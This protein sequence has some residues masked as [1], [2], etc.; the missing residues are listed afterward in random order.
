MGIG[1]VLALSPDDV[2]AA[3]DHLDNAGF[4]SWEIGYV[5]KAAAHNALG[6]RIQ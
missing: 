4:P 5:E 2:S 1:F 3:K 6:L